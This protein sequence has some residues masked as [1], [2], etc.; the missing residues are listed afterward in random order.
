M[1]ALAV[2][3]TMTTVVWSVELNVHKPPFIPLVNVK[4]GISLCG[5][6]LQL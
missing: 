5:T 2:M 4:I 6:V 3:P 1:S